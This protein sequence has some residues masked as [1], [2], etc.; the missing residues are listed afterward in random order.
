MSTKAN[1]VS[2]TLVAAAD[3]STKQFHGIK[4]DTNGQAALA[5][6]GEP[7]VGVLQNNPIA[8][9]SATVQVLGITKAK[10]AGTIAAGA[11]VG[12]NASAQFVTGTKGT[13]NTSD[14]GVAADAL[15]GGNIAGIA[16][17][18][19]VSGDLFELILMHMGAVPTTNA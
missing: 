2:I 16:K 9:Q 11:F 15:V 3:L 5:V 12:A 10:A 4:I 14:A 7:I 18:A 19:A 6:L 17:T 8:G 13:T 1:A